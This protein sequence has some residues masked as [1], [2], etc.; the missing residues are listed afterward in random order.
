MV[1]FGGSGIVEIMLTTGGVW[2]QGYCYFAFHFFCI[3]III[4][5]YKPFG[6]S[7]LVTRKTPRSTKLIAIHLTG[8]IKSA[9]TKAA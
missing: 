6:C 5:I 2:I 9:P 4:T 7:C 1:S 3:Q 8:V